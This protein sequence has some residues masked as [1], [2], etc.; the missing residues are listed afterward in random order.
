MCVPTIISRPSVQTAATNLAFPCE[1]E[2]PDHH[3]ERGWDLWRGAGTFWR[4]SGA[5]TRV[6]HC[7]WYTPVAWRRRLLPGLGRLFQCH[8]PCE[9]RLSSL[10]SPALQGGAQTRT[11]GDAGVT[12]A[13][14][15]QGRHR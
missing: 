12:A 10:H 6:I 1:P 4:A 11:G 8:E 9:E 14:A 3:G 5:W 2:A 15:C 7:A 13:R